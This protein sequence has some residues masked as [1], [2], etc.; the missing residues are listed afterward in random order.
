MNV[1]WPPSL[2]FWL[3]RLVGAIFRVDTATV[4]MSRLRPVLR[5]KVV[6]MGRPAVRYDDIRGC[7]YGHDGMTSWPPQMS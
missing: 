6:I 2:Y 4:W 3:G 5:N 1:V 7:L